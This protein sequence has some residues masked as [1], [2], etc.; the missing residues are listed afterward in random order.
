M[1]TAL[2]GVKKRRKFLKERKEAIVPAH[3]EFFCFSRNSEQKHILPQFSKQIPEKASYLEKGD[4]KKN[5]GRN[6]AKA[7]SVESLARH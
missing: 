4:N 3:M 6:K 5:L 2:Y 1:R 7:G